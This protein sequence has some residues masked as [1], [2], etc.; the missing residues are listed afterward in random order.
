MAK[1]YKMNVVSGIFKGW[2]TEVD[3]IGDRAFMD[4][5]EDFLVYKDESDE[6]V[7]IY[8]DVDG[9][10]NV[11][12]FDFEEKYEVSFILG[13]IIEAMMDLIEL[14][15]TQLES[16]SSLVAAMTLKGVDEAAEESKVTRQVIGRLNKDGSSNL[17]S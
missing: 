4:I 2:E 17:P 16:L 5:G 1:V 7:Q 15:S 9:E 14:F 10:L 3:A 13:K 6:M 11:Y 12:F 8:S